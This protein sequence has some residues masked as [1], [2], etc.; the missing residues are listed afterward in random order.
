MR[1]AALWQR[2]DVV[3]PNSTIAVNVDTGKLAWHFSHAP[4]E[5]LDLDEVFERVLVDDNGRQFVFKPRA[6]TAVLWKNDRKTGEYIGHK[7]TTFPERV[8]LL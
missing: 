2:G 5:S 1:P 4:G 3:S 7:E 6:R 8:D